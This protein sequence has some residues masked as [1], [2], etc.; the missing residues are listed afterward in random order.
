M[1]S[2][3]CGAKHRV[4]IVC[5]QWEMLVPLRGIKMTLNVMLHF[6]RHRGLSLDVE[7]LANPAG[8]RLQFPLTNWP[9]QFLPN[10]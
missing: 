2:L 9:E 7:P 4:W 3:P 5:P 6:L 1:P 8:P 10:G